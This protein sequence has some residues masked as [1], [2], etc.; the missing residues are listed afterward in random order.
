VPGGDDHNVAWSS[1]EL[2][3]VIE[4]DVKASTQDDAD[5]AEF[6][7]RRTDNRLDV[8]RPPPA[9]S[10]D[11]VRNGHAREVDHLGAQ[12]LYLDELVGRR[13]ASNVATVQGCPPAEFGG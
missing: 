3:P 11:I 7:R 1:L 6:A 2:G 13:E 9:W 10:V 5:V 8:P 4:R 12:P